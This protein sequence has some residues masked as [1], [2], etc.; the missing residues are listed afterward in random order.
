MEHGNVYDW[1]LRSVTVGSRFVEHFDSYHDDVLQLLA[2]TGTGW[3]PTLALSLADVALLEPGRAAD[4]KLQ[5]FAIDGLLEHQQAHFGAVDARLWREQR[6]RE[7]S[8]IGAAYRR[9]VRLYAGTDAPYGPTPGAS[10]HREL[11][12]FVDAGIPPLD[13]LRIATREAAAAVGAGE[14]LGTIEVGKLADIVI[15]SA[16]PLED[17]EN[18][19]AVWRVIK[20]GWVFDP[21]ELQPHRD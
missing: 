5:A 18:S 7:L 15:L 9:G 2:A 8:V 3:S 14:D 4:A 13:V 12:S 17:I 20:G 21:E 6:S 10:L 11:R 1:L 19:K 16:N